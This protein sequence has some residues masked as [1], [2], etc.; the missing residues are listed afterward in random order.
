MSQIPVTQNVLC[1]LPH[2]ALA[3]NSMDEMHLPLVTSVAE[4]LAEPPIEVNAILA[5]NTLEMP[6]IKDSIIYPV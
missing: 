4:L 3:P 5:S 2:P 1:Q 6:I